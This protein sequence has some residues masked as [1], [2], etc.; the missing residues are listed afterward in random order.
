[1]RRIIVL[2][3]AA[4]FRLCG[5]K[6]RVTNYFFNMFLRSCLFAFFKKIDGLVSTYRVAFF[7]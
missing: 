6:T 2:S 7:F 4:G 1:M 5:S 3:K